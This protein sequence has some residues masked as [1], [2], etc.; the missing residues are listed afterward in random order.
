ME[1]QNSKRNLA[2]D[3]W[4]MG[5]NLVSVTWAGGDEGSV[6]YKTRSL[7]Q[8]STDL[9]FLHAEGNAAAGHDEYR[10]VNMNDPNP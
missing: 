8:G 6:H 4:Y 3:G 10:L 5:I 7:G 1:S 2:A 9:G